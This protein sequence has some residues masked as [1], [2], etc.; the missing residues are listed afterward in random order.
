M[1]NFVV[2]SSIDHKIQS[3]HR[4]QDLAVQAAK[5]YARER[6]NYTSHSASIFHV[7]PAVDGDQIGTEIN[8]DRWTWLIQSGESVTD[9]RGFFERRS[10]TVRIYS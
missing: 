8:T 4:T 10:I 1:K 5:R 3:C 6:M 7:A 2:F 9:A